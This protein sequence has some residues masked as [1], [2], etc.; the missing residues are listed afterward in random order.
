MLDQLSGVLQ[1]HA[2]RGWLF[3]PNPTLDYDKPV[4]LLRDG[5]YRK[6]L[7]AI[8]VMAEGVFV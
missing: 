3:S 6:V 5:D 4:N 1:P 8:D 2:A 7:G